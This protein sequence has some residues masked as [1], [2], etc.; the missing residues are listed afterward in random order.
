MSKTNGKAVIGTITEIL[1]GGRYEVLLH[2]SM[3]KV[4]GYAAGKMRLHHIR[5]L[6]GDRVDIVLD[7]FGG[8][9]TNR[10]VKRH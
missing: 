4:I 8:H 3:T 6:M 10:I 7:P 5:V 2:D 1:S 9:A